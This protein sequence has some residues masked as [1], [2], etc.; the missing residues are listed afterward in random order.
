MNLLRL[1]TARTSGSSNILYSYHMFTSGTSF[2]IP[3]NIIEMRIFAIGAGG[4]GGGGAHSTAGGGGGAGG[5]SYKTFANPSGTVSYTIGNGGS[6]QNGPANGGSGENT[7][8]T[9]GA[10]TL[11]GNG[12]GGGIYTGNGGAG[13]SYSGGDAG[14]PGGSGAMWYSL[15]SSGAFG[16]GGGGFNNSAIAN[17]Q[18]AIGATGYD[19]EH[20]M[21]I[22]NSISN[23]PFSPAGVGYGPNDPGTNGTAHGGNS[24]AIGAGGGGAGWYGGNGGNGYLGGGGGGA[25]GW[26]SQGQGGAGGSGFVVIVCKYNNS[27]PA[28]Y[29]ADAYRFIEKAQITDQ[30]EKT[31]INTLVNSLKYYNLWAKF[32]L[33]YP[34]IGNTSFAKSVN[35]K[36]VDSHILTHKNTA[37][38]TI[39]TPDNINSVKGITNTQYLDSNFNSNNLSSSSVHLSVYAQNTASIRNYEIT[40]AALG[41]LEII[42]KWNDDNTW[43]AMYFSERYRPSLGGDGFYCLTQD[44]GSFKFY[45]AGVEITGTS[46]VPGTTPTSGNI[47]INRT[48]G[49]IS[50]ELSFATVGSYLTPTEVENLNNVIQEFQTALGRQV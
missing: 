47:L 8:V 30:N 2:V 31:A 4:G 5:I 10:T 40:S 18:T 17:T 39:D 16:G 45:R 33:I 28:E 42:T 20:V 27:I 7:V 9:F 24:Y 44:T 38:A 32:N 12:G 50:R 13:G 29:D 15:G 19:I 43:Y 1:I 11:T 14:Q 35:L 49:P 26:H 3:A 34:M 36:S 41:T 23:I 21:L 37:S 6:G 25:A 48:S 46:S 22:S